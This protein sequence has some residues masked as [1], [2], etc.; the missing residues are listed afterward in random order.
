MPANSMFLW[1]PGRGHFLLEEEGVSLGK[2]TDD[3]DLDFLVGK[4][5][6]EIPHDDQIVFEAGT[7]PAPLLYAR[8]EVTTDCADRNGKPLSLPDLIGRS[9]A[10]ASAQ[11]GVL[12]LVFADG[13]TLRCEPDRF[14]KRG[15]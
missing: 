11:G 6:V 9:V 12:L 2:T 5:V 4:T 14:S 10:S 8:I 3:A 13:A 15:K 7:K 1:S